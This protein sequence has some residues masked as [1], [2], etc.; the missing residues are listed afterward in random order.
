M[1]SAID[2]GARG[3]IGWSCNSIGSDVIDKD[4]FSQMRE[5]NVLTDASQ[6]S[7]ENRIIVNAIEYLILLLLLSVL[8]QHGQGVAV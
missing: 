8:L 2:S 3:K 6:R 4:K 5:R 7:E 1:F